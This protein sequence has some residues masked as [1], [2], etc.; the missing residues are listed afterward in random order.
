[1]PF[2]SY[3]RCCACLGGLV[4]VLAATELLLFMLLQRGGGS[5]ER[6]HAG[7]HGPRGS[8]PPVEHLHPTHAW[9]HLY[10][11]HSVNCNS[12][13]LKPRP[14]NKRGTTGIVS[15]QWAAAFPSICALA[16]LDNE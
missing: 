11:A 13:L 14:D 1:M 4:W 9:L 12:S 8:R 2:R 15:E 5:R 10:G 7:R 3:V 16:Q 6:R